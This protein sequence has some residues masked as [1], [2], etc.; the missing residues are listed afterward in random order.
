ML[1]S[2]DFSK[3]KHGIIWIMSTDVRDGMRMAFP[4]SGC[5][6]SYDLMSYKKMITDEMKEIKQRAASLL[7]IIQ[8]QSRLNEVLEANNL[9]VHTGIAGSDENGVQT[10]F[11]DIE[12]VQKNFDTK[13]KQL[14]QC[15]GAEAIL[16]YADSRLPVRGVCFT[17][18]YADVITYTRR[19]EAEPPSENARRDLK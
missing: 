12:S 16:L 14:K 4:L 3:I 11:P 9:D 1:S 7:R 18:T 19:E 17:N 15:L 5:A 8:V 6:V 2:E 10:H 13:L